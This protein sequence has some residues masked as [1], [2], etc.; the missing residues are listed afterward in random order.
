[1][2]RASCVPGRG[3]DRRGGG[4][5]GG[6]RRDPL[7][8]AAV[9][10]MRCRLGPVLGRRDVVTLSL[11][12]FCPPLLVLASPG[13]CAAHGLVWSRAGLCACAQ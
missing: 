11:Y 6:R 10:H 9:V 7:R 4:G 3:G 1:M 5:G 8:T 2:R 13:I 12:F